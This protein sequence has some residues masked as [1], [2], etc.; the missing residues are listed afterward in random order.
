MGPIILACTAIGC[1]II[2]YILVSN[3]IEVDRANRRNKLRK[4]K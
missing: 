3:A 2:T 4:N 1:F